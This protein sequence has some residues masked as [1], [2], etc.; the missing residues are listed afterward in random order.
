MTDPAA[1]GLGLRSCAMG[2]APH[3]HGAMVAGPPAAVH[4]LVRNLTRTGGDAA[5][6]RSVSADLTRGLVERQGDLR[7]QLTIIGR[8]D[9]CS[10][11]ALARDGHWNRRPVGRR[12][13]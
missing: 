2:A 11:L 6:G 8:L 1:G 9:Q 3:W 4:P 13:A 12:A 7:R 5:N 10:D